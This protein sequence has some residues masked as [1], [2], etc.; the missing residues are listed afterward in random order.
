[1]NENSDQLEVVIVPRVT[2]QTVLVSADK[3][4]NPAVPR[5]ISRGV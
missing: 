5:A 3:I 2:L 1:M 4:H